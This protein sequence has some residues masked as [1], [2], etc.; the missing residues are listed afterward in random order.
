[1]QRDNKTKPKT[2]LKA[3]RNTKGENIPVHNNGV[4]KSISFH[5]KQEGP[6]S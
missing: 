3:D 1:M 6:E 2:K 4:I 5:M